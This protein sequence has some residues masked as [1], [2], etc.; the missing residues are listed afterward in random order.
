MITKTAG[1]ALGATGL[2]IPQSGLRPE[3]F[4]WL[5]SR[6]EDGA[7]P[8]TRGVPSLPITIAFF[9]DGQ[10]SIVDG[11]HRITLAREAGE[12]WVKGRLLGYGARGGIRWQHTGW[13]P[14]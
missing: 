11:R 3:S 12:T 4:A 6:G 13:I 8:W 9:A 2:A 5:K 7:H 1:K 14:I 10:R